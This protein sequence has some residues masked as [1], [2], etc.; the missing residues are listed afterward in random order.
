M[1]VDNTSEGGVRKNSRQCVRGTTLHC[2]N[3]GN[4]QI[5]TLAHRSSTRPGDSDVLLSHKSGS[6]K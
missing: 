4:K 3:D 5:H 6:K 2:M 1:R